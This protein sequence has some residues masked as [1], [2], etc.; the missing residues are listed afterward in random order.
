MHS[1]FANLRSALPMN[2][3][4]RH[5]TFKVWGGAQADIERVT[6]IWRDCLQKYGGPYLFG[7]TPTMAD[8]MYAPVCT[9]FITYNVKLDPA[10]AGYRDL[11]VRFPAVMEW[12]A[13]AK[14]EHEDV[15]ELDV[16][17]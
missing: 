13:A 4:V 11:M 5:E 2:L 9:R 6:T 16:E 1:G 14:A 8:A 7:K 12:T 15:E 3:K 10:S 17:F